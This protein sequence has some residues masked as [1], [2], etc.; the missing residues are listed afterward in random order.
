MFNINL[1]QIH[2]EAVAKL[3]GLHCDSTS[4]AVCRGSLSPLNLF[5]CGMPQ[6]LAEAFSS[7]SLLLL[8]YTPLAKI[9]PQFL[10]TRGSRSMSPELR[11][12]WVSS[13]RQADNTHQSVAL[14][15]LNKVVYHTVCVCTYPQE[16]G[17][18]H[19]HAQP[20]HSPGGAAHAAH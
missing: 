15:A 9:Y 7:D 11:S 19:A 16:E 1:L 3:L 18:D 12:P 17:G 2:R 8:S 14:G 4:C 10:T 6:L 5:T 20:L 13:G